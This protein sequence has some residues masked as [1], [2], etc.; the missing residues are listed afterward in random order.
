MGANTTTTEGSTIN[1][2]L[3]GT[4]NTDWDW[5]AE[6]GSFNAILKSI[7]VNPA[8][9][10]MDIII[11][12]GSATGIPIFT[13]NMTDTD[14]NRAKPYNKKRCRPYIDADDCTNSGSATIQI[15]IY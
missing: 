13:M 9:A 3:H 10:D 7:Q 5:V 15:E 1:I 6:M 12:D 8:A 2:A 14:D 4:H 11:R